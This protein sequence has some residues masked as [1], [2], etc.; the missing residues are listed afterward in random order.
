MGNGFWAA[1]H[2]WSSIGLWKGCCSWQLTVV[3][4]PCTVVEGTAG[5]WWVCRVRWLRE[6]LVTVVGVPCTVPEATADAYFLDVS[7]TILE[8]AIYMD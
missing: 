5:D 1:L 2:F 4:V 3:G 8:D 6:L 7:V